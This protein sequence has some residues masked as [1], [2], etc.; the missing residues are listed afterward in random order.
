MLCVCLKKRPNNTCRIEKNLKIVSKTL[1][2]DLPDDQSFTVQEF[3]D[4]Q[5]KHIVTRSRL[6]QVMRRCLFPA[7]AEFVN[8][9]TNIIHTLCW[10]LVSKREDDTKQDSRHDGVRI[11]WHVIASM[12]RRRL[13]TNCLGCARALLKVCD[14]ISVKLPQEADGVSSQFVITFCQRHHSR[15]LCYQSRDPKKFLRR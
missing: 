2:V 9:D 5:R 1:L 4:M 12:P 6:L 10:I 11:P 13:H 3:V 15:H 8:N 7:L 14:S